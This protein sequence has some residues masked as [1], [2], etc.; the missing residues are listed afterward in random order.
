METLRVRMILRVSLERLLLMVT[1]QRSRLCMGTMTQS[2][3]PRLRRSATPRWRRC[4]FCH[5]RSRQTV[6]P[7]L[8][9]AA[10]G[11]R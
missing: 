4:A 3:G 9:E 6:S 7:R 1:L 8:G 2:L 5:L 10:K 11:A